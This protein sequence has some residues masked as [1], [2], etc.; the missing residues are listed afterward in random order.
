M[1]Q[2][3]LELSRVKKNESITIEKIFLI[4]ITIF[5]GVTFVIQPIFSVPDEGAHFTNAYSVFHRETNSKDLMTYRYPIDSK[6][7]RSF[8]IIDM[9]TKKGDYTQDKIT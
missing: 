5:A 6:M 2:V 9:Y 1:R 3:V 8:K 7:Y 4:L